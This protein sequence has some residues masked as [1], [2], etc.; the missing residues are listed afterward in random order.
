MKVLRDEHTMLVNRHRMNYSAI[1]YQRHIVNP[2]KYADTRKLFLFG[3]G[4]FANNFLDTYKDDYDVYAI[5]DNQENKWGTTVNGISIYSPKF[6]SQFSHGE[7][8]V[9][10]CVKEF[11]P[12]ANARFYGNRL[13][14]YIAYWLM[15]YDPVYRGV[16]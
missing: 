16:S 15:H 14:L 13:M 3:S 4:K 5:L 12:I 7:Y 8:W 6:L 2:L 11:A 10:I 9:L 1:D